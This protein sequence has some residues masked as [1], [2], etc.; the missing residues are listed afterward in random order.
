LGIN[1]KTTSGLTSKSRARSTK[2]MRFVSGKT[3]AAVYFFFV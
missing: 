2:G 3:L 1:V